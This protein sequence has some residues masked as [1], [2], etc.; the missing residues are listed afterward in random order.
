MGLFGG[1]F[2][3]CHPPSSKLRHDQQEVSKRR[4]AMG[5]G[6]ADFWA[7]SRLAAI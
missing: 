5:S 2:I 7:F 4:R 6:L 1:F 3:F